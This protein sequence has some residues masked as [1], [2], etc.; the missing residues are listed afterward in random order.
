MCSVNPLV[1]L[2]FSSIATSRDLLDSDSLSL[3]EDVDVVVLLLED[4]TLISD[5]TLLDFCRSSSSFF[6]SEVEDG[7]AK[8]LVLVLVVCGSASAR[9]GEVVLLLDEV[10]LL[11]FG[12]ILLVGGRS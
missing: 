7:E 6:I 9:S 4:S 12:A 3:F 1:K 2:A 10:L 5:S 11:T 8:V